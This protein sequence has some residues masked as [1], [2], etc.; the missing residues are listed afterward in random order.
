MTGLPNS[1]SR[2]PSPRARWGS[3]LRSTQQWWPLAIHLAL[4]VPLASGL[5]LWLDEAYTLDTTAHGPARALSQAIRFEIQAP[6][7]FVILSVWRLLSDSILWA[8]LFSVAC[9]AGLVSLAPTLARR[10]L[11]ENLR[12][13]LPWMIA[14]HPS[15]IWS[16][17]ETRNYALTM[18]LAGALLIRWPDRRQTQPRG[19]I[20][21][22][23]IGVAAAGLYTNYFFGFFLAALYSVDWCLS[24]SD[25][26]HRLVREAAWIA[27]C[28][29]P[30]ALC[31]PDQMRIRD[32]AIHLES[33]PEDSLYRPPTTFVAEVKFA[34]MKAVGSLSHH[35]FP[36]PSSSAWIPARLLALMSWV[37]CLL[38]PGR[39]GKALRGEPVS[40]WNL[41]WVAWFLVAALLIGDSGLRHATLFVPVVVLSVATLLAQLKGSR[42]I[43]GVAGLFAIY[44]SCLTVRYEPFAKNGDFIRVARWIEQQESSGQPIFVYDLMDAEAFRYHYKGQNR[45]E[46]LP[47]KATFQVYHVDNSRLPS[48][49]ALERRL[50]EIP[51]NG[52][53]WLVIDTGPIRGI[54]ELTSSFLRLDEMVANR[55]HV[56]LRRTFYGSDVYL[57]DWKH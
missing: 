54:P 34:V 11:P 43:W 6:L 14:L 52:S 57:L 38:W 30:L 24:K 1:A 5:N 26:R 48:K 22:K 16:A 50:A 7:Y 49:D 25:Y 41:G 28:F 33:A 18:L 17:V 47:N 23:L 9:A 51:G 32:A 39:S 21:P 29:V 40:M 15:V 3:T 10:W 37:L 20:D 56:R 4:T 36:S 8:R 13:L 46:S 53:L 31:L 19:H 45:V 44:V 27:L 35:L 55:F 12:G 42:R 2:S